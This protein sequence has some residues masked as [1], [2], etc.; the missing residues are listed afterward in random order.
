MAMVA[1]GGAL[2][3]LGCQG[4]DM[5]MPLDDDSTAD[6]RYYPDSFYALGY[7]ELN[8][9][10]PSTALAPAA[11]AKTRLVIDLVRDSSAPWAGAIGIAKK[12]QVYDP[13][14]CTYDPTNLKMPLC[15]PVP[16]ERTEWVETQAF[17][18]PYLD[19]AGAEA[20][21]QPIPR[22]CQESACTVSAYAPMAAL[23]QAS[24]G[25]SLDWQ[26]AS[27]PDL[28]RLLFEAEAGVQYYLVVAPD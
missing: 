25:I 3:A 18:S 27:D 22:S 9:A 6:N 15:P 13:S 26:D 20:L 11:A 2:A 19:D 17:V 1:L 12:V 5:S 7:V 16:A 10:S 14:T 4:A 21:L 8:S 24:Q 23:D 28:L